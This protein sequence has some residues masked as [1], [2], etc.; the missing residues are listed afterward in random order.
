MSR[1]G[2]WDWFGYNCIHEQY[3]GQQGSFNDSDEKGPY[4][5]DTTFKC[6]QDSSHQAP[7]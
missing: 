3:C 1:A 5:Y 6:T 2:N 4:S 7:V